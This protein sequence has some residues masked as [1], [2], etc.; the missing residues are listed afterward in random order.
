M[1]GKLILLAFFLFLIPSA[2]FAFEEIKTGYDLYH[3]LRLI[4]N[5][6]NPEDITKGL[7]AVG[8]LKG[9]VDGL[10]LMQDTNY[11]TMFPPDLMSEEERI[12]MSK[13]LNFNRVNMPVEGIASGQLILIYNNFSEKNPNKLNGSARTCVLLSIIYAYGWK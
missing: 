11:E 6:Q 8:F 5:P 9:C 13:E 3:N 2:L 1:R 7:L 10:I 12:K 4:D